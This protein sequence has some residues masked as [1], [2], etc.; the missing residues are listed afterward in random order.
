MKLFLKLF[1]SLFILLIII[2]IAFA[3]TFDANDYK[4]DIISLVKDKTGRDLSIPGDISLSLF[5]WIGIDLGAIQVSNAKGFEK[6]PFAKMKHLQVRAKLWPLIQQKLEADTIVIEGLTLNLAKNKQGITNWDDLTKTTSAQKK[7][8]Q[9]KTK[10]KEKEKQK[11]KVSPQNILAAIALNGIKIENAQF[12]WHDQQQKQNINI[13]DIQLS[14]GKL[15]PETKIPFALQFTLEEKSVTASV[16]FTNEIEISS[17]LD[18]FS[19][20]DSNLSS[21]IK[22]AT[23]KKEFAPKLNSALMQLNLTKQTFDTQQLNLSEGEL[24]VQTKVAVKQLFKK[25]AINSQLVI[26]TFDPRTLAKSLS[27][28]LPAMSD[29]NA[30]KKVSAQLNIKGTQDNLHFTNI[31]LS[32][33]DT[34]IVGNARYKPMPSYSSLNLVVDQINLDRYL[35]K[36]VEQSDEIKTA[37]SNR[38]LAEAAIIPVALLSVINMDTDLSVNNITVKNTRWKNLKLIG[39]SKNG[40]IKIKPLILQGYDATITSQFSIKAVKKSASLSG[41]LEIK[42]ISAGKLFNDFMK[43]DKLR[44][45]TSLNADFTTSGIK[46]TQLKQNLN[47]KLSLKLKDGTLKGFDLNHKQ[48]VLE[49]KIKRQPIPAAPTPVETKIA[50]LT[51]TAIIRNGVLTNKD[52]RAAT[53]LSRIAGQGTVNIPKEQINYTSSVKFT[54]S[55]EIQANKPYEKMNAVPLDIHISGTFAKPEVKVDYQKTLKQ[56]LKKE[57]KKKKKK[58]TDKAKKKLEDKLKNKLKDLFKF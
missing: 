33:D 5:P 38:K 31:E 25:P 24:N 13:K 23:L 22:L 16:N 17:K 43:K 19:F 2:V 12:N 20:H 54:S 15:R 36:A 8:V 29:E 32:L 21:A 9:V 56:L 41:N 46:L 49:A 37:Q 1:L 51:A 7:P 6:K 40:H 48:K 57:V 58:V 30:L 50:N 35:P 53:P 4:K 45:Q 39:Q 52:L 55:K 10:E 27:V 14:L 42:N 28:T 18:Q 3:V 44:G 26:S 47:G 11:E 34:K